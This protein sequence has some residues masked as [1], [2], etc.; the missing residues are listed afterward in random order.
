[1]KIFI[2]VTGRLGMIKKAFDNEQSAKN[3]INGDNDLFIIESILEI[4][5][6]INK[7]NEDIKYEQYIDSIKNIKGGSNL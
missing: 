6:F 5:S 3:Y 7:E 2:V 4:T 1:M